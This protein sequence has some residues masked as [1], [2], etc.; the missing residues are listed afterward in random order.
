MILSP[1]LHMVL[2]LINTFGLTHTPVVSD[3]EYL[4][5]QAISNIL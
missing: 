2:L 4:H 1:V 5:K 3:N